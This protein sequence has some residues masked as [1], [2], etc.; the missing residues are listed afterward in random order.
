VRL[1]FAGG[2]VEEHSLGVG[3]TTSVGAGEAWRPFPFVE[4]GHPGV[5]LS[6]NSVRPPIAQGPA[7]C[8]SRAENRKP[9]GY[10]FAIRRVDRSSPRAWRHGPVTAAWGGVGSGVKRVD[11]I[12]P[13]GIVSA[14]IVP[15]QRVFVVVFPASVDP[16]SLAVRVTLRG[17]RERTRSGNTHLIAPPKGLARRGRRRSGR[18]GSRRR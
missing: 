5:C 14:K 3:N 18:S 15:R 8:A 17:G 10:W 12:T 9:E 4:A 2:R 7:I 16:D 6:F 1:R 11:V 13:T